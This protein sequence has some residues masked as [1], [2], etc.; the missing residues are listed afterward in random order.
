MTNLSNAE[1]MLGG[2]GLER[3][4]KLRELGL[5]L[6]RDKAGFIGVV[7][8]VC[9]ILMAFSAPLIAPHDPT[10]QDLRARLKPP[11]W[12][13]K[14]NWQHVLGTDHLGRDV[15]S[16]VIYGSRVSLLVGTAVMLL[17][18]SFGVMMGLLA[19]YRGE[20]PT[21]LSCAG[22]IPR[23]RSRAFCWH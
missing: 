11:A 9:L 14:G 20:R 17:A 7:L 12:S 1:R 2:R 18:G 21:V 15:L 8:M 22:L 10:A 13:E 3:L 19:G 4:T 6:W 5:E 16:R 23:W